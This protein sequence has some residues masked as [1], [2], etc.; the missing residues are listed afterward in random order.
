MYPLVAELVVHGVGCALVEGAYYVK[1]GVTWYWSEPYN[2]MLHCCR[3]QR[4]SC[5]FPVTVICS[6]LV[7]YRISSLYVG[8]PRRWITMPSFT[9]G[10]PDFALRS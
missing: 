1:S 10:V 3:C 4:N 2:G 7:I 5:C 9:D 6:E 8:S